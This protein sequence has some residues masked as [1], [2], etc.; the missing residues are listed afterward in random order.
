MSPLEQERIE[1]EEFVRSLGYTP[2][3]NYFIAYKGFRESIQFISRWA[4]LTQYLSNKQHLLVFTEKEII[5]RNDSTNSKDG[6][7]TKIP[8]DKIENFTFRSQSM[9]NDAS[10]SFS[11]NNKKF[12][13]YIDTTKY[14]NDEK[15]YSRVNFELLCENNFHG[16]IKD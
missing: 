14:I 7:V 11:Y 8:F 3:H 16:L 5:L 15:E 6:I 10:I 4:P 1:N 13:F 12:Y 9:S 2:N